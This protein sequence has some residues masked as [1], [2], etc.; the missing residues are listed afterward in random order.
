MKIYTQ[1]L[2]ELLKLLKAANT[3]TLKAGGFDRNMFFTFINNCGD[4][5]TI[6]LEDADSQALSKVSVTTNL[7]NRRV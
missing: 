5:V 6:T 4:T 1:D 2:E 7:Q 3:M